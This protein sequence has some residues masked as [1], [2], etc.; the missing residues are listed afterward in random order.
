MWRQPVLRRQLPPSTGRIGSRGLREIANLFER[1]L[2]V[3][4]GSL[5][6]GF[7]VDRILRTDFPPTLFAVTEPFSAPNKPRTVGRVGH[8]EG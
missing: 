5:R 6:V 1:C 8:D 7:D 3:Q 2:G 4:A